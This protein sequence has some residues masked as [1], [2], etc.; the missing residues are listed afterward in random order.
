MD[1][2]DSWVYLNIHK[3]NFDLHIENNPDIEQNS[4][5]ES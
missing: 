3:T 5:W 2:R 1:E 4:D